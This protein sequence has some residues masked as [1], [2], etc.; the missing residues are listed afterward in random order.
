[1]EL[2]AQ[3]ENHVPY[4]EDG[5]KLQEIHQLHPHGK[6]FGEWYASI[7]F[8]DDKNAGDT[9]RHHHERKVEHLEQGQ[10]QATL[11]CVH[12]DLPGTKGA[13]VIGLAELE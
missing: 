11:D 2:T 4:E 9:E 8:A 6:E 1:M 10:G 3:R 12:A 13:G 5:G 7:L